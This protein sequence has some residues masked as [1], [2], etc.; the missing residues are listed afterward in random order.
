[1]RSLRKRSSGERTAAAT[2]KRAKAR[3]AGLVTGLLFRDRFSSE[4]G[5]DFFLKLVKLLRSRPQDVE[6]VASYVRRFKQAADEMTV[7]DVVEA[8]ALARVSEVMDS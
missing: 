2:A 6:A 7:E 8:S 3:V 5:P 4:V 1:M